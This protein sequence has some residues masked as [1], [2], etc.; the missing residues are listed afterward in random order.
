MLVQ[1]EVERVS[2]CPEAVLRWVLPGLIQLV[3]GGST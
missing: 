1:A 3:G 2:S